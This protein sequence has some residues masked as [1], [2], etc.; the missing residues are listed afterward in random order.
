MLNTTQDI[1]GDK[2]VYDST[3]YTTEYHI[4]NISVTDITLTNK[5]KTKQ[6]THFDYACLGEYLEEHDSH[7]PSTKE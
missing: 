6:K 3:V 4:L 1:K 7:A 5:K 2:T